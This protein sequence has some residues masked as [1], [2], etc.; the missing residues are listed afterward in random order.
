MVSSIRFRFESGSFET[1][2]TVR[3]SFSQETVILVNLPPNP[4]LPGIYR[5][6][7][8]LYLEEGDRLQLAQSYQ[9]LICCFQDWLKGDGDVQKL[10]EAILLELTDRPEEIRVLI[11]TGDRLLRQLPWQEWDIFQ[12]HYPQAEF[13]LTLTEYNPLP[14]F[15]ETPVRD[16]VRILAVVGDRPHSE[17]LSTLR[18][19][20]SL[21]DAEPIIFKSAQPQQL[22]LQLQDAT[23]WDILFIGNQNLI[24]RLNIPE[25]KKALEIACDRGLKL[26]ICNDGLDLAELLANLVNP[27]ILVVFRQAVLEQ[28]S[29]RFLRAFLTAFAQGKSL[30]PAVRE[31]RESLEF[32]E[33]KFPGI[34]G[35]PILCQHPLKPSLTWRG[36]LGKP[37]V[38][39]P[40]TRQEYQTRKTLLQKVKKYWIQGVLD[41]CL[42]QQIFLNLRLEEYPRVKSVEITVKELDQTELILPAN[43]RLIQYFDRLKT[44]KTLLILGEPGSGKTVTLLELAQ[45]AIA[46]GERDYTQP[47][48][49]VFNLSSWGLKTL[50]IQDWII[51]EGTANYEVSPSWLKSSLE[52]GRLFLLLDGLDE[53]KS[54][55]RK[56]CLTALNA[57]IK[58]YPLTELVLTSRREDYET[59]QFQ[60]N[61]KAAI[62]LQPLSLAQISEYIAQIGV[63]QA[64]NIAAFQSDPLLIELAKTP[65]ML[66]I[67]GVVY[68]G[69]YAKNGAKLGSLEARRRWLFDE[70]INQMWYRHLP[71]K[72]PYHKEAM[73][74]WLSWLA[75]LMHQESQTLFFLDRLQPKW[76]E[77]RLQKQIPWGVGLLFG[78]IGG[79]I[80]GMILWLTVGFFLEPF[81]GMAI[82]VIFVVIF[83]L[84]F[85][86]W[87]TLT[88]GREKK[89][90]PV[91][92]LN[93]S[94]DAVK[95]ALTLGLGLGVMTWMVSRMIGFVIVAPLIV[96]V[97]EL[98]GGDLERK[99]FSNQGIWQSLKN[100]AIL[101]AIAAAVLGV[102]AGLMS[103][104]ILTLIIGPAS[105]S[106][107]LETAWMQEFRVRAILSGILVGLF[108]GLNQAGTACIQHL[109]MR[110]LLYCN[111]AIPWNYTRFLDYAQKL[112]FL[113]RVGSGYIFIHRLLLEH[114]TTVSKPKI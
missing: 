20:K 86:I 67:I 70:Y 97:Y 60:L 104:Q 110:V 51:E 49:L 36:I 6:W 90:R 56:V 10:R 114:F 82:S 99:Q 73:M 33:K 32:F 16:R 47:I 113:Q 26:A 77:S 84:P 85:G 93:W 66:N 31:G 112:I 13:A 96:L 54:E 42:Q 64:I 81:W 79:T 52:K 22:Y 80:V 76:L 102:T 35:L 89:I 15:D 34:M 88:V 108:Y 103:E 40:Q 46:R 106:A 45:D 55:M 58:Q 43:T 91:E 78:L 21:P 59:I 50:P 72:G 75:Q 1:G 12:K 18:T 8:T 19:L 14:D 98:K 5:T 30:Y 105:A 4:G 63:K 11:Q 107:R 24:Q 65:L 25:F 69:N 87:A 44:P 48:P 17:T 7:E 111:G 100:A 53:V 3:I 9:A 27:P 62:Y 101:A 41:N 57:F 61:F 95:K 74:H 94:W 71:E 29:V 68:Q 2:F 39:N 23:G 38:D 37:Q 92:T 83:G 28:L 109:T